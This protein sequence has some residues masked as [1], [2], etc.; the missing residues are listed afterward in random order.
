MKLFFKRVRMF[1]NGDL[2]STV[3]FI[4]ENIEKKYPWSRRRLL[5]CSQLCDAHQE[6]I[7]WPLLFILLTE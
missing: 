2:I 7:T 4:L 6:L 3:T 5:G 1:G